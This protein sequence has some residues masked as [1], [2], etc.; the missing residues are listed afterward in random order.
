M[1]YT[2]YRQVILTVPSTNPGR[3]DVMDLETFPICATT[4]RTL[5]LNGST[6]ELDSLKEPAGENLPIFFYGLLVKHYTPKFLHSETV[7]TRFRKH[8]RS[9]LKRAGLLKFRSKTNKY[10]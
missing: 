1:P 2:K 4:A 8:T 7:V 6:S 10:S 5:A 9:T 3:N